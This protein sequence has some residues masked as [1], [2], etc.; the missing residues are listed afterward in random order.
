M[1]VIPPGVAPYTIHPP[2]TMGDTGV[3]SPSIV[4]DLQRVYNFI[5]DERHLTAHALYCTIQQ[6]IRDYDRG[7]M[8]QQQQVNGSSSSK[9]G[10]RNSRTVSFSSFTM[11]SKSSKTKNRT[12]H[13]MTNG[14]TTNVVVVDEETK[15]QQIQQV[16][17][18]ISSKQHIFDTLEVRLHK[19]I[20]WI[21]ESLFDI[22][23]RWGVQFVD[24]TLKISNPPPIFVLTNVRNSLTF[25]VF[26]Q[27]FS[28]GLDTNIRIVVVCFVP[29]KG[30]LHHRRYPYPP[31]RRRRRCP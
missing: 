9:D 23:V 15:Q 14:T 1:P 2:C 26:I 3:P 31:H 11:K 25:L 4:N 19:S 5:Q 7:T 22:V 16:K 27:K 18:S 12:G 17:D 13:E 29:H 24:G 10:K 30:I 20:W 21:F 6:R 28:R 8:V